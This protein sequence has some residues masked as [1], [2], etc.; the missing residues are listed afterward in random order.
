MNRFR[1]WALLVSIIAAWC[2][3]VRA[4]NPD[5][6]YLRVYRLIQGA[7]ALKEAGQARQALEKYLEAREDLKL[8]KSTFPSWN[9]GVVTFRLEYLEERIA[10]LQKQFPT[11]TAP[12][13]PD[14][15]TA[16]TKPAV[17]AA[18]ETQIGLLNDEIIRLRTENGT[19]MARLKEALGARP[20]EMS[21]TEISRTEERIKSLEK[22]KDLT[23][24]SLDQQSDSVKALTR[25]NQ[26]LKKQVADLSDKGEVARVKAQNDALKKQLA[27]AGRHAAVEPKADDSNTQLKTVKAENDGLRRQVADLNRKVG[28]MQRVEDLKEEL[29]GVKGELKAQRDLYE[30]TAKENKKLESLLLDPNTK[31]SNPAAQKSADNARLKAVE[32]ERDDLDRRVKALARE[33]ND[34]KRG[35]DRGG[36]AQASGEAAALR[37]QLEAYEAKKTPYT[38]EELALFKK[39]D[40]SAAPKPA[41]PDKKA[42][43][44]L[45]AGS[46]PLVADA[47]RA[48]SARRFDEAEKLYQK[49]LALDENNAIIL[50]ELAAVQVV[51]N[52]IADAERN[53]MRAL[54][55]APDDA[56]T[57]SLMGFV[58]YRQD[59]ADESVQLLS[60]AAQLDSKNPETQ[61]RLGSAW[62]LKGQRGPAEA[63]FRKAIQ[64]APSYA[65]AHYNLAVLYST[66][67]K[68]AMEL[69]K[70]HYRKA[71]K[72]GF[73]A[74]PDLEKL[75]GGN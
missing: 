54:Q 44:T 40:S 22:D 3:T 28:T 41:A 49:V 48:F 57:L 6:H 46:G 69:A 61:N 71:V 38:S 8:L 31:L 27:D 37:A 20:K 2:G 73:A 68:P 29:A 50:G 43:K 13:R 30:I 34:K 33:L 75:M 32:Q 47:Q 56:F 17:P 42:S 53:L 24:A 11:I 74:N 9:G 14:T 66:N 19:L 4:D 7:D 72:E 16:D 67:D 15:Q 55:L 58:K 10:P 63:A 64:L 62:A 35:S 36:T 1:K 23:R 60:R 65:D 5:D 39:A 59:K 26:A 25:E 52:R 21:Q 45:P 18:I 12:S 70:W 51:Q